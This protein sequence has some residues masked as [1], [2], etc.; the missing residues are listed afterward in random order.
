LRRSRVAGQQILYIHSCR[1]DCLAC[2]QDP[3]YLCLC[4]CMCIYI[5]T[6]IIY[7]Y[8]YIYIIY[9]ILYILYI[10][11]IIYIILYI[12][13]PSLI[14]FSSW[15]LTYAQAEYAP[16]IRELR[17]GRSTALRWYG[18]VGT[19]CPQHSVRPELCN[20]LR[21]N[22]SRSGGPQMFYAW[23]IWIDQNGNISTVAKESNKFVKNMIHKYVCLFVESFPLCGQC[24]NPDLANISR[25]LGSIKHLQWTYKKRRNKIHVW[26]IS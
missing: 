3:V 4:I 24:L 26:M 25:V 2:Q 13:L 8:Y 21:F 6:Y 23:I 7:I 19:S 12:Y 15:N 22:S 5:C 9:Y 18:I 1:I 17:A 14:K 20:A 10:I 16:S 11:Y